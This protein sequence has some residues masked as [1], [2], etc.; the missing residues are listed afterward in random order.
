M[1]SQLYVY[2]VCQWHKW[3]D[4]HYLTEAFIVQLNECCDSIQQVIVIHESNVRE[5]KWGVWDKLLTTS[6]N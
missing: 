3:S 4:A 1:L 5:M 6:T 2:P